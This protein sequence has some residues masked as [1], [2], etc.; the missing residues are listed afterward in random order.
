MISG[1]ILYALAIVCTGLSYKKDRTKTK[2]ALLQAWHMF[3]KI[4]PDVMAIMLFVGLS[5]AILSPSFISSFIGEQSGIAGTLY[6]T[7]IGSF[8]LIPGFVVFPLGETLVENGAGLPQ[9]AAFMS[10]L[11][12]VGIVTLPME[13]K[14]F[15]R[16]FA[17]AR[18]VAAVLL[19][20]FLAGLIWGVSGWVN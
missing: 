11:M 8:A 10:S 16:S 19:S 18:N 14:M 3:R 12:T 20:V 9:V 4:M 15:G 5:L 2:K 6:A 17:Y 13:Q 7:V 1:I